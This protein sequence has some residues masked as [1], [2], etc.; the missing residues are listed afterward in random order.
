MQ[1]GAPGG[2]TM[3]T[4]VK[5]S[6]IMGVYNARPEQLLQAVESIRLQG[7][8]EWEMILYDD[9]SSPA[10]AQRIRD[11]A[12]LDGR[13][14]CIR[15]VENRGLAHAL[16]Q[17]IRH[18]RGPCLARMDADDVAAPDRLEKQ[19][20]FLQAHPQYQWVG[21]NALLMD[22]N[23]IWGLQKMPAAPQAKDFLPHSPYIHPSVL[24]R[25]EALTQNGGYCEDRRYLLCEDYE[26]FMRLHRNGGRGYNLQEPL[27]QYRED[28]SAYRRRTLARRLR[29]MRLRHHGFQ[30]L[31]ILNA[32]TFPY[33]LKPLLA[34]AAPAA[35]QRWLRRH[36]GAVALQKER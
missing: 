24:F 29:E 27:L 19:Y 26:L 4:E 35:L 2:D 34:G 31:G 16:N 25:R 11:A 36:S 7:L 1:A 21:S 15:G 5:I 8:Q 20:T 13:I 33:V 22:E 28:A 30:A 9:G 6:V 14:R 10:C 3:D 12:S 18:A 23:G 17:C 32:A